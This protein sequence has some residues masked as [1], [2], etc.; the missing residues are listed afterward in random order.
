MFDFDLIYQ[1]RWREITDYL[2][3]GSPP[4]I[5]QLL[6]LNTFAMFMVKY[7]KANQR[8]ATRPGTFTAVQVILILANAALLF[9][10]DLLSASSMATRYF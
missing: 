6:L 4:L 1:A 7:R 3:A 9:Q 8:Y 2:V 5:V 10:E